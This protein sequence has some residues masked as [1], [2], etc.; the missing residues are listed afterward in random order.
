MMN[1]LLMEMELEYHQRDLE[2]EFEHRRLLAAA[3]SASKS[4]KSEERHLLQRL[5]LSKL[6][7]R[8]GYAPGVGPFPLE[9][10]T[11]RS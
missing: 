4:E 11:G 1:P 10:Q 8:L 2:A 7:P 6:L 3:R 5:H 9:P